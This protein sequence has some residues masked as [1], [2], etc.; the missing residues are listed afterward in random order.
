MSKNQTRPKS[1]LY[2]LVSALFGVIT[3]ILVYPGF[4]Y[5]DHIEQIPIIYREMD[6]QFLVNDFFLNSSSSSIARFTYAKFIAGIN[7]PINNLPAVFLILIIGT[8]I[9]ISVY[10]FIFTK[11]CFKGSNMAGILASAISMAISTFG[12]GYQSTVYR[13]ALVPSALVTP[14]IIGSLLSLIKQDVFLTM[15]LSVIVAS[16][17]PLLGLEMGALFLGTHGIYH[18]FQNKRLTKDFWHD[19]IPSTI[20][21]LVFAVLI[22]LP[23]ASQTSLDSEDF[24][25]ILAHFRH[26]HH[27][28]FSSFGTEQYFEAAGFLIG[29]GIILF[30]PDPSFSKSFQSIMKILFILILLICSAGTIF[31]EVIPSRIWVTGQVYRLLY[32]IKWFGLILIAG[33]ISTGNKKILEKNLYLLSIFSP[34]AFG[35]TLSLQTLRKHLNEKG[36]LIKNFLSPTLILIISVIFLTFRDNIPLSVLLFAVYYL[37]ILMVKNLTRKSLL[38]FFSIFFLILFLAVVLHNHLPFMNQLHPIQLISD[39]LNQKYYTELEPAALDIA[40]YAKNNTPEDSVFLTPADWG[41]FRLLAKRAIVIDFKAF[42][43]SDEGI[44]GWY[45]RIT[46]CYG[47]P[48]VTGFNAIRELNALYMGI[49]DEKLSD[50]QK[51]YGFTH[52]VLYNTTKTHFE[53]IYKN[54]MFKII[55]LGHD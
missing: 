21:F 32:F 29:V 10:T 55:R 7:G 25:H 35:T 15:M 12:L 34:L 16:L 23:Q 2:I 45:E 41:E 28:I 5:S 33:K 9:L 22:L 31:T 27:Y 17:H 52:V 47:Q 43:F 13:P 11:K 51:T 8:N 37:I 48:R 44:K 3:T 39:T 19:F 38:I 46:N 26:P 49:D 6:S 14:L 4:G 40:D 24:I 42:P 53:V 18:F 1:K 36:T 20:L 54:E 50:L 30:S